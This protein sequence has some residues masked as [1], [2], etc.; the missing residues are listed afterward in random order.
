MKEIQSTAIIGM[1]ARVFNTPN[2]KKQRI[3]HYRLI[4]FCQFFCF[5][6]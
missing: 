6:I 5:C 3:S 2:H 4:F 1:G